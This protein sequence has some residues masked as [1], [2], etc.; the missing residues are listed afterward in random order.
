MGTVEISCT[1][2]HGVF[3][4]YDHQVATNLCSFT[5]LHWQPHGEG[6]EDQA[7]SNL[8]DLP[9]RTIPYLKVRLVSS[10]G[11]KHRQHQII[12]L[13]PPPLVQILI[14]NTVPLDEYRKNV[15]QLGK[16]WLN[17][18]VNGR[19][20]TGYIVVHVPGPEDQA[21]ANKSI[22]TRLTN[23]FGPENCIQLNP[24]SNQSWKNLHLVV[25]Q[26]LILAFDARVSMLEQEIRKLKATKDIP[27]WNFGTLFVVTESLASVF[28]SVN[29]IDDALQVYKILED[30]I[31]TVPKK[32]WSSDPQTLSIG[33]KST[34]DALIEP[35][36][37]RSLSYFD[38]Q[39]HIVACQVR[40]FF[41]LASG[42]H[43]IE[44]QIVDSLTDKYV[45][46]AV[47][48]A[49]SNIPE[50]MT[51]LT[52]LIGK[53]GANI[54]LLRATK[55]LYDWTAEFGS[56]KLANG[57]GDILLIERDALQCLAHL[58]GWEIPGIFNDITLSSVDEDNTEKQ[59]PPS[60]EFPELQSEKEYRCAF[61]KLTEQA[62]NYFRVAQLRRAV[63]RLSG[64]L[65][66]IEYH[67][68][69]I[70]SA[71]KIFQASPLASPSDTNIQ[72][73]NVMLLGLAMDC[74]S[75]L[76]LERDLVEYSWRII[77]LN[78]KA[79]I[80][81]YEQAIKNIRALNTS[82]PS[83]HDLSRWYIPKFSPYI[84]G[85]DRGYFVQ[86][87]LVPKAKSYPFLSFD[88]ANMVGICSP[89][90]G[91]ERNILFESL[92]IDSD[93]RSGKSITINLYTKTFIEG[94][95]T[96]SGFSID[97]GEQR[98]NHDF[99]PLTA[100]MKPLSSTIHT[101]LRLSKK[102]TM[103]KRNVEIQIKSPRDIERANINVQSSDTAVQLLFD[104]ATM[105]NEL[106]N[107]SESTVSIPALVDYSNPHVSLRV[108]LQYDEG[109]TYESY[110]TVDFSLSVSV[111]FQEYYR[112][113]PN[114]FLQFLVRPFHLVPV[115]FSS[116]ELTPSTNYNVDSEFCR[117]LR[118]RKSVGYT[119]AP[120][121]YVFSLN[122]NPNEASE[123]ISSMI[124]RLTYRSML[125]EIRHLIYTRLLNAIEE[126]NINCY[127][128]N[129][130]RISE[131]LSSAADIEMYVTSNIVKISS[132]FVI[133]DAINKEFQLM[134]PEHAELIRSR[135]VSLFRS[136]I[137]NSVL[138]DD[139][140]EKMNSEI[141]LEVP[142]PD[143]SVVHYVKLQS[144]EKTL[145]CT[146]GQ[147]LPMELEI[148]TIYIQKDA[149]EDVEYEF[150]LDRLSDGWSYSGKVTGTFKGCNK[151]K[152]SLNIIP[153]RSGELRL[154]NVV[155]RPKKVPTPK[156]NGD[157]SDL[158][159][160]DDNVPP[161]S[162]VVA[163]HA[164]TQILVVP[165]VNMLAITF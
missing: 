4:K 63:S 145:S 62:L 117:A 135:A 48:M 22:W 64:Q 43:Q 53:Q 129:I 15:R 51:G 88:K 6:N 163:S 90:I 138:T 142:D 147:V 124:L 111:D 75:R 14:V 150:L 128:R 1:D 81:L 40:L 61:V 68:G 23:E 85:D 20:P 77:S 41:A 56:S 153:H 123:P 122:K 144:K 114:I 104:Q 133:V 156:G 76:N 92:D 28:E 106:E 132:E 2:P 110:E 164:N 73:H 136:E 158:S 137:N 120:V 113:P 10:G 99:E 24:S 30:L 38:V 13:H 7:P 116:A 109:Y 37:T 93:D 18:Q 21:K 155:I 118:N 130:I 69:N 31:D 29:L 54:W 8:S 44:D 131:V 146:V 27:G 102:Y 16:D 126:L 165:D 49:I 101:N 55:E 66:L 79:P 103:R 52:N 143:A 139:D 98:L 19:D 3:K 57:K 94:L 72:E 33:F 151:V 50:I 86:V 148:N 58:I 121:S 32:E 154:P 84:R 45:L 100:A 60:D 74:A 134:D 108:S 115:T 65:A 42:K 26:Q 35:I 59:K 46:E 80:D 83:Q 91:P 25:Q 149:D 107:F 9:T 12:G 162:I 96:F 5:N 47:R 95:V 105:S 87:K 160:T 78:S 82:F 97:A 125:W 112:E 161:E 152:E 157:N 34:R 127:T 141:S 119:N 89:H 67:E 11:Y 159:I 140:Y 36:L 70:E 71:W 39:K 17:N